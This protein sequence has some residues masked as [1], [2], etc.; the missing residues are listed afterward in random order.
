[1]AAEGETV[2]PG[3]VN[4][5]A[6]KVNK[7][8]LLNRKVHAENTTL[9]VPWS[10]FFS[11]GTKRLTDSRKKGFPVSG[12]DWR[13]DGFQRYSAGGKARILPFHTSGHKYVKITILQ[14]VVPHKEEKLCTFALQ[15]DN[16]IIEKV[17]VDYAPLV[18]SVCLLS[19]AFP[20]LRASHK[21]EHEI[22]SHLSEVKWESLAFSLSLSLRFQSLMAEL[23]DQTTTL[24]I[25]AQVSQISEPESAESAGPSS[26]EL[27]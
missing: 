17:E 18:G 13:I 25:C 12:C 5:L 6:S 9:T 8:D 10:E 7:T 11:A 1:M 3:G 16:S 2:T 19:A 26:L 14:E 4:D 27:Y 20:P 23:L 15:R 21:C 22:Q 24:R